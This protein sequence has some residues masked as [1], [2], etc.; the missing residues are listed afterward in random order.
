[1]DRQKPRDRIVRALLCAA[2]SCLLLCTP[3]FAEFSES[4]ALDGK[5]DCYL[6]ELTILDRYARQS[7]G[8]GSVELY[9]AFY[10]DRNE[11]PVVLS[12]LVGSDDPLYERLSPYRSDT[13]VPQTLIAV[14]GYFFTSSLSR[15][16]AGAERLFRED[17][18]AFQAWYEKNQNGAAASSEIVLT[19]AGETEAAYAK[20]IENRTMWA[21]VTSIVFAA[22]GALCLL[23]IPIRIAKRKRRSAQ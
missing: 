13:D 4:G 19:F 7:G 6:N 12:L 1:M 15:E 16:G 17:A 9:L 5:A 14:S 21:T 10:E 3:V 8:K 22:I 11:Q 18:D 2:I 20:A 23:M